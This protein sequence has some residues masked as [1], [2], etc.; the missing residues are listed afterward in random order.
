[1]GTGSGSLLATGSHVLTAAHVVCDANFQPVSS[2]ECTFYLE[3]G[4]SITCTGVP[5]VHPGYLG[6]GATSDIAV[7]TLDRNLTGIVEIYDIN[8]NDA[9]G[10]GSV[11]TR[12]GYGQFG[13]G[14]GTEGW[15]GQKRVGQNKWEALGSDVPQIGGSDL[16]VYDFDDGT[17][18]KDA[19]G[20]LL[21]IEDLGL[22]EEEA[23]GAHGDSGGPCFVNGVIVGICTGGY[24]DLSEFGTIGIDTRV[25]VYADWIDELITDVTAAAG[26]EFLVNDE[27]AVGNQKWSDV[28][29]DA[30]GDFVIT[31]TSMGQDGVGTGY[32]ADAGGLNGVYARRYNADG[33]AA[34]G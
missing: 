23:C 26:D 3:D 7:I 29:V 12:Y 18:E 11:Y 24:S 9:L 8:R 17:V 28:A 21:G 20:K 10:V 15:D 1:M 4:S 16:L 27:Y 6:T 2:V 25:S 34:S 31:W 32:G 14:E 5:T 19:L 13:T 22:G 33:T 30:D